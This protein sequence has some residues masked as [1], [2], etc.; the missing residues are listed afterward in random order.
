MAFRSE[1]TIGAVVIALVMLEAGA[2]A[3]SVTIRVR[4][5]HLRKG[6]S[7]EIHIGESAIS[8]QEAGK[9]RSHSRRWAYD[10]IQ[11]LYVAADR[12]RLLTYED[13][14]WRLGKDREYVF[15]EL[16]E[17]AAQRIVAAL[18][19]RIDERRVVAAFPDASI[20]PIWQVNAKLL[21]GRGGSEGTLLVGSDSIV[22]N[23]A[24]R[25]ASRR[26]HLPP[27]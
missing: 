13:V 17:G 9:R 22:Y 3:E 12:I 14:S 15:D 18:R 5:T 1:K 8:F 10:D 20:Q 4:H 27:D 19:G 11:Q 21:E 2:A 6:G 16:P 26:W 24:E 25:D 7:G 23:S